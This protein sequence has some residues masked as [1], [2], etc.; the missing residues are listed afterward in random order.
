[1]LHFSSLSSSPLSPSTGEEE[2]KRTADLLTM[3]PSGTP[4]PDTLVASCNIPVNQYFWLN[5]LHPTYPMHDVVAE[6]VAKALT[7]GPNVC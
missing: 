1:M 6:Q 2:E 3:E 7:E 4:A 5:S